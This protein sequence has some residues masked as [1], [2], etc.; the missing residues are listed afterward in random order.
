MIACD[1]TATCERDV[2]MIDREGYVYCEGHG[3]RRRMSQPCRKLR[4]AEIKRITN[5]E[6][7]GY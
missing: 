7:I 6:R 2:A 5:G 4:P 3:M 1:M